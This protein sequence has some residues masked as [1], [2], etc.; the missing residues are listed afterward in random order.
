M[1]GE[2]DPYLVHGALEE[3]AQNVHLQGHILEGGRQRGMESGH[4]ETRSTHIPLTVMI[5]DMVFNGSDYSPSYDT[6]QY[7]HI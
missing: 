6:R 7:I 1:L 5:S 2:P 4:C 3:G